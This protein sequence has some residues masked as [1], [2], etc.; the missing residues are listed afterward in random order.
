MIMQEVL[1]FSTTGRSL[2]EI[3]NK[4]SQIITNSDINIGICHLF[5][6]HTSASLIICEN[7]DKNVQYDLEAYMQRLVIDG[8]PLFRHTQEGDDDMSAHIRTILTQSNL[9]IPIAKKKLLLGTWQGIYLWE[10][11]YHPMQRHVI[12]TINYR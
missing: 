3:T 11:R 8:D 7:A 1:N 5:L 6:Q 12:V 10:H 4:I 9:S 2:V